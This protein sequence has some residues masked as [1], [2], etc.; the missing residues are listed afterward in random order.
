[1]DIKESETGREFTIERKLGDFLIGILKNLFFSKSSISDSFKQIKRNE[2]EEDIAALLDLASKIVAERVPEKGFLQEK[3]F[4]LCEFLTFWV[5]FS[6]KIFS[7]FTERGSPDT[8]LMIAIHKI[9]NEKRSRRGFIIYKDIHLA[10]LKIK[11][12]EKI[13]KKTKENESFEK[14]LKNPFVDLKKRRY[15]ESQAIEDNYN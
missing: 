2:E 4:L 9:W 14:E 13:K 12:E 3:S 11:K 1:M 10:E 5:I 7:Q 15:E 8:C 6:Q